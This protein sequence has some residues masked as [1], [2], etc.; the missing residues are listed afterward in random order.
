[1]CSIVFGA[2]CDIPFL[3][4]N[5]GLVVIEGTVIKP[6]GIIESGGGGP[7]PSVEGYNSA[8]GET[9]ALAEGCRLWRRTILVNALE[10]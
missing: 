1:M 6:S 8:I 5:I 7:S 3:T 4:S 10:G 9:R 2:L